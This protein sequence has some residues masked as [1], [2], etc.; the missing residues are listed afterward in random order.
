MNLLNSLKSVTISE[1]D[2][3]AVAEY[4]SGEKTKM[5]NRPWYGLAFSL[6]G[7]L[8]Y[9]HND[10]K[11]FLK[12][13]EVI[14][15]PMHI[16]YEAVAVKPGAFAVVNFLTEKPLDFTEFSL[17]PIKNREIY[18]REFQIM[19]EAFLKS[20]TENRCTLL[21]SLYQ[22]FALLI[23]DS[24]KI[25]L[26]P[27]LQTAVRY[28][29]KNLN[30][31]EL[32]NQT[33]AKNIDISEV[34][35]RKLF[36]KKLSVSVN[37]YVQNKRVERAKQLLCETTLSVTE[38]AEQCGFSCIYYFCRSFKKHTGYTPT[39]YKNTHTHSWL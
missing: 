12:E 2:Y 13:D 22:M 32:S 25:T 24:Q 35:L 29:E 17:I 3:V 21:S 20:K 10:N 26:P 16:T 9:Q 14:F 30:S 38:I 7:E 6:G 15:I 37:Q 11:I 34:Y 39:E 36:S 5:L 28:I 33:I 19:R 31:T 4:K 8:Y 27:V 18:K 23:K 1:V